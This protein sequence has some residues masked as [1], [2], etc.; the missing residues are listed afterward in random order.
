M[1]SNK[2]IQ[3]LAITLISSLTAC[4]S[5]SET[6]SQQEEKKMNESDYIISVVVGASR[7]NLISNNAKFFSQYRSGASVG[8]IRP[9]LDTKQERKLK[10][11]LK[12]GYDHT[13]LVFNHLENLV[14]VS[15]ANYPKQGITDIGFDM[16]NIESK[17]INEKSSYLA[18][19]GIVKQL[20]KNGW[21][22]FYFESEPRIFGKQSFEANNKIP[23]YLGSL[24]GFYLDS[25]EK[26]EKYSSDL[27]RQ[28]LR[29]YK[30][31]VILTINFR[32]SIDDVKIHLDF[33]TFFSHYFYQYDE[34]IR[35]KDWNTLLSN[36]LNKWKIERDR[37]E[38]KMQKLGYSINKD[39]QNP[40]V[41]KF[42][43]VH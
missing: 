34:K 40:Y 6:M 28:P 25:E 22:V 8:F 13:V 35:D 30:N 9:N 29:F 32:E 41:F 10:L 27:K 1:S 38:N 2:M 5:S 19:E 21:K 4:N 14:F 7:E 15:D 36:D 42:L 20:N 39:Y 24:D 23:N 37:S 12:D 26:W 16:S 3:I 43:N 17:K 33:V 18:Y 11:N 31:N